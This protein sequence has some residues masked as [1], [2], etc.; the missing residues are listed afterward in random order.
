MQNG[1][2]EKMFN[3]PLILLM[4]TTMVCSIE[5]IN[6]SP[7][8]LN[9]FSIRVKRGGREEAENIASDHG[10]IVTREVSQR[11]RNNNNIYSCFPWYV[12]VLFA[13]DIIRFLLIS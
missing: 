12:N 3:W 10:F 8:F 11:K 1:A 7:E 6:S 2:E 9:E 13:I 4:L 5:A